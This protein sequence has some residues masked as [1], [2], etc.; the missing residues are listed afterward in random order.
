MNQEATQTFNTFMA[1]WGVIGLNESY[2]RRGYY[3]DFIIY[4]L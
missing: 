2:K 1:D 4:F 3:D